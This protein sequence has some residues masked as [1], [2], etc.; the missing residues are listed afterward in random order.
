MSGVATPSP[1]EMAI[2]EKCKRTVFIATALGPESFQS[3]CNDENC[4]INAQ[5]APEPRGES[6]DAPEYAIWIEFDEKEHS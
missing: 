1:A 3:D 6:E 4:P 5:Y 2:C